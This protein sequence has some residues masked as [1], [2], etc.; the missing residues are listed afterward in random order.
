MKNHKFRLENYLKIKSFEEKNCWNAVL[1]QQSRVEKIEER[2]ITLT[3]QTFKTKE[4]IS[5]LKVAGSL[6][7]PAV[8]WGE[9]SVEATKELIK[10]LSVELE[11]EFKTLERLKQKHMESKKE[12]KIVEKLKEQSKAEYR[13][14][15]LKDD[16]KK[17]NEIAQQTFLRNRGYDE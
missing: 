3:E 16:A 17:M 11:K 14:N 9:E 8:A 4:E 15:V 13:E 1:Q 2:I 7:V 10:Q 6:F 5:S 12:L